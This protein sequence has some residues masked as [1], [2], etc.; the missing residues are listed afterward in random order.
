MNILDENDELFVPT[1]TYT[2]SDRERLNRMTSIY[3]V[4]NIRIVNCR[5]VVLTSIYD[6]QNIRIVNCRK[7]VLDCHTCIGHKYSIMNGCPVC[8]GFVGRLENN[9]TSMPPMYVCSRCSSIIETCGFGDVKAVGV[10]PAYNLY[11]EKDDVI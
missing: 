4:Q 10:V 2:N 11:I 6:V 7:V 8:G 5:K 3:D 1:A 9:S